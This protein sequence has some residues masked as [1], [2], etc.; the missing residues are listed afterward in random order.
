MS[1]EP[2]PVLLYHSVNRDPS[3]WIAPFT[4]APDTFLRHLD[5]I[6]ESGRTALTVSA[7]RAAVESGARL[8][9]PVVIT[10]DD[11]FRD[12]LEFAAPLLANRGI[13]ATV[14]LTT[15]FLGRRSPGGDRMVSWSALGEFGEF[16]HALGAHSVTHPQLDALPSKAAREEIVACKAALEDHLGAPVEHFAYPH[17]YSSPTVRR[18]VAEGG[19]L[20]ACAVKNAFSSRS[21]PPYTIARL[22][23][24]ANTSDGRLRAWLSGRGAPPARSRDRVATRAWRTYRRARAVVRGGDAP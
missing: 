7:L 2:I 12:T 18:L 6:A 4:V 24:M 21:D 15:G 23:V 14:F 10:F 17:G 11:G 9:H 5:L 16:G 20:S 13:P 1:D 22:T 8:D 19:Y 3:G